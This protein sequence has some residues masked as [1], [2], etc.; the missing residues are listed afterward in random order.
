[1]KKQYLKLFFACLFLF[2][3]TWASAQLTAACSPSYP[4]G[5]SS[6]RV[7]SF[8]LGSF[9]HSPTSTVHDYTAQS[10]SIVAGA[11]ASITA[12]SQ[13]YCAVATAIDFNNDGDFADADELFPNPTYLA[14]S[15]ATYTFPI[16]IP[17][18]TAPGSYRFRIFSIGGNSG[19]GTPAGSACG[20]YGYGNWTDYTVIITSGTPCSGQPSAGTIP[21]TLAVCASTPFSIAATGATNLSSMSNQWQSRNPAGTGVWTNISGA[22]STSYISPG[23]TSSTDF[24]YISTCTPSSL[25]DTSNVMTTTLNPTST[26]Y[27]IPAGTSPTYYIDSFATTGGSTNITNGASGLSTNGYGNFTSQTVTQDLGGAVNF[28]G[29]YVTSTYGTRIWVDWNQNGVL[30]DAGEVV[31]SSST[32][33]ANQSGSFS[34]PVTALPGAT[35][36]RV[37]IS[38]TA[39]TGPT[40]PCLTNLSGEYEDYTFIVTVPSCILPSGLT[41]SNVTDSSATITWT[42][43]SPAPANGYEYYISTTNTA[44][45]AATVATGSVAA[46]IVT[47]N[48]TALTPTSPYYVWVRSVCSPSSQ[49]SWTLA[50]NFVT[51][52]PGQIGTGIGTNNFLPIYSCYGYNYSQQIYLASELSS[53]LPV[54]N[55]YITKIRFNQTSA[56]ANS[57]LYNNWTV[58]MGNTTKSSFANTTDWVAGASLDQ[59]FSGVLS[60]L[61]GPGWVEITLTNPFTWDGTSNIVIGVDENTPSYSCTANWASFTASANR[62]ILYY[63]DN[64]NPN[65]LSPPTANYGPTANIPQVQFVAIAPPP[66]NCVTNPTFPPNNGGFCYSTTPAT[67]TW[68]AVT[69]A[70]SYDLYFDFGA[71]A[72]TLIG[73]FATTSYTI[74]AAL[75]I[76]AYSWKIVPIN[77][78]GS[79]TACSTFSFTVYDLPTAPVATDSTQCG[80]QVPFAFVS[81]S[82]G[83][84]GSGTFNWYD[85]ATAGNLLQG[86]AYT[87]T[88]ATWYSDNYSGTVPTSVATLGGSAAIS[89]G[90]LVLQPTSTSN[91]GN[92]VIDASGT[93]ATMFNA[94]FDVT[95]SATGSS[96][97]DGF[98]YCFGDDVVGLSGSTTPTAEKGSGSKLRLMFMT[99]NN[100]GNNAKGVYLV[101]NTI[102]TDFTATAN[103]V[104]AY[105]NNNSWI[106][107]TSGSVTTHISLSINPAGEATVMLGA[108]PLFS[109]IQ[110][111]AAYLAENKATWKHAI[112]SRSGGVSG[113]FAIDNLVLQQNE[114]M[115]GYTTYQQ[116]VSTTTTFY[117]SETSPGG[118][119]S[120]RTP[121]TV[122]VNTA[123]VVSL[124]N[125]TAICEGVTLTLDAGNAGATFLW[126]DNS[127]NQTLDATTAGTYF[128]TVSNGGCSTTDTIEV[129][130]NPLP[131]VNLG[132]DT[133][134][135]VGSTLT[136][137]AGN[138]GATFLW[139]DNSTNQ[140]LDVT[141]AGTYSVMVSNGNCSA[142]DTIEVTINQFPVVNLGADT[143]ICAGVTLTLDAGNAGAT[144]LWNDNSTNQTL[145]VTAA[146]T[147]SVTASNGACSTNDTIE[148]TI[149]P[150]PVVNLGNDTAI[151]VGSTL[152]LDAENAGATFLWSDNSTNQTLDVTATGTYSVTVTNGSCSANSTIDVTVNSFPVVNLGNDTTICAGSTLTLD[153][154]N[155]GASFLWN[156]NSANQTLDVTAA[157]TYSVMVSNGNCSTTDS[158]M[159]S[160]FTAPSAEN[161]LFTFTGCTFTFSA[162]NAQN[163][164][165][166]DWSFGDGSANSSMMNP[167]HEYLSKDSF[168]V[169]LTIS[170]DCNEV[171]VLSKKVSC[172]V[173]GINNINLDKD[174]L[175]L[176]PN[177]TSG[178]I[179]I[180]NSSNLNM[181][182]ITI[183]DVLGRVVYQATPQSATKDQVDISN[184]VSGLYTVHIKTDKGIVVKKLEV[185]K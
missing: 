37:G 29:Q 44:P 1:M 108:T 167:T 26:C 93:N 116:A 82:A 35:R 40:T 178:K 181:E 164:V 175:N 147:Y 49:S 32:Y 127:T 125:D 13:G 66:P 112:S 143:A 10:F 7:T 184:L 19:A 103:G 18:T 92:I 52:T 12:I 39:S 134:I 115:P 169:T 51:L 99:Y 150:S 176:Y 109:N 81:S 38:Y 182:N 130:V 177:P 161:I 135:C 179:T 140:T 27:C 6:W 139:N 46:G 72:T 86:Q 55:T 166:Y 133:A 107:T 78:I 31:Y 159:V 172:F 95:V 83:V 94:D 88:A 56:A 22:T 119:E 136:L 91:G 118:C 120:A 162:V 45:S 110:L 101:Y 126:N 122:T 62:G 146:G 9:N 102:A 70:T 168:D 42:A 41:T 54:G 14:N 128:V 23:I 63:N 163:V 114:A 148:V 171:A 156:D 20:T 152:T 153:A 149:N 157:G 73:N 24:R 174:A 69:G 97:A 160:T 131:V 104:L 85:A 185:L 30:D 68:P 3:G 4:S 17:A 89:G 90:S 48:I 98:S 154:G 87:A 165:S 60:T 151:C 15:P 5:G 183:L 65:P 11:T 170:N 96:T 50:T 129:T 34:V 117:V 76:G 53:V 64:T 77:A 121:V 173:V 58:Y 71:T 43:A 137:D 105:S 28:F 145:D 16:T 61:S 74:P 75:P 33:A 80:S 180:E 132:N 21:A 123:P 67:L 47:K 113:G 106:P 79:A 111:P 8:T 141:A 144:Y 155:A 158:I 84:N 57:T 100:S 36:M 138:A 142:N 25:S 124:G 2:T 59:V